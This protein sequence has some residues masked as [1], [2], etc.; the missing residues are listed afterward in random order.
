M[1]KGNKGGGRTP[2]VVTVNPAII[3]PD[4]ID[5]LR[6]AVFHTVRDRMKDARAVL[7]GKKVWSNQQVKLYLDLMNKVMP[8]LTHSHHTREDIPTDIEK[9]SKDDIK[10]LLAQL[11]T[12]VAPTALPDIEAPEPTIEEALEASFLPLSPEEE[13]LP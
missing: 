9:M 8:N 1:T 13:A 10:K 4:E 11:P 7:D 5:G 12:T 3:P 2:T 6:K